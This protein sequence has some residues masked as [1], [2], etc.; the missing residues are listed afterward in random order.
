MAKRFCS[1]EVFGCRGTRITVA[2]QLMP[3]KPVET[4][5]LT[6][7][8]TED[9][10]TRANTPSISKVRV[11]SERSLCDH[12]SI[13]PP[14]ITSHTRATR[15][16][17][18]RRRRTGVSTRA[19]AGC[20]IR[21]SFIAQRLHRRLTTGLGGRIEREQEAEDQG[22]QGGPEEAQRRERQRNAD[23]FRDHPG[24]GDA[25]DIAHGA[26]E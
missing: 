11:S 18:V 13:R 17:R 10:T 2:S 14:V 16:P 26:A 3:A 7:S 22:H 23:R 8:S 25:D 9:I 21:T 6:P 5:S 20:I 1:S 4:L 15:V 19:A 12:S 24:E